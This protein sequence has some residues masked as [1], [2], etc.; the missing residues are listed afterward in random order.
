MI[1]SL[2]CVITYSGPCPSN[3]HVSFSTCAAKAYS[4]AASSREPSLT[5]TS[6]SFR[7]TGTASPLPSLVT[8]RPQVSSSIVYISLYMQGVS[9][10][11]IF[12]ERMCAGDLGGSLVRG[13]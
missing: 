3:A 12:R 7:S 11:Y 13:D 6:I 2:L 5:S 10:M 4:H 1:S 8:A 9:S